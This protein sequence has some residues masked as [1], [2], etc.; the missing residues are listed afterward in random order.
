MT[1]ATTTGTMTTILSKM[2][3]NARAAKIGTQTAMPMTMDIVF[4]TVIRSPFMKKCAATA[5]LNGLEPM[6]MAP[7]APGTRVIPRLTS[8]YSRVV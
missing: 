6:M 1:M 3:I 2:T 4:I 8:A 5:V 7:T